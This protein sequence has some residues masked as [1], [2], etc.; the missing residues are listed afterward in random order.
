MARID[1]EG[2]RVNVYDTIAADTIEADD[3]IL[4]NGDPIEVTSVVDDGDSIMV[5]GYSYNSGDSVIVVLTADSEVE[6]WS[7]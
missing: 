3:Q 6:L 1:K 4:V 2:Y 5:K 7:V